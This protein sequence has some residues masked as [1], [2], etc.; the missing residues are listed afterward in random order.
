VQL[1]DRCLEPAVGTNSADETLSG[2][3]DETGRDPE[4]LD[5]DVG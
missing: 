1:L 5:A 2:D 3:A 4:W